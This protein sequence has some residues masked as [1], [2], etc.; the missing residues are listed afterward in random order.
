MAFFS[1]KKKPILIFRLGNKESK[2]VPSDNNMHSLISV[3]KE[4]GVT[5][6]YKVIVVPFAME[7]D[8]AIKNKEK[9]SIVPVDC[10]VVDVCKK[11]LLSFIKEYGDKK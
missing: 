9:S 8:I 1:K 3:C 7:V 2:W 11:D 5:K 10:T 6:D 4:L